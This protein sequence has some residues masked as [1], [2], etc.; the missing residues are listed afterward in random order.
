MI[1]AVKKIRD[2]GFAIEM[3]DFGTGYSALNILC[4]IPLDV[5]K[6]DMSFVRQ[7]D[8]SQENEKM[9]G[10]ILEMAKMLG[11]GVNAEGVE[12]AGQLEKL[13]SMGCDMVQGFYFSKP[14]PP[15]E[16]E[17]LIMK[18]LEYKDE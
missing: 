4:S 13:N 10:I 14:V 7:M 3:D 17:K 6:L 9:V 15:E 16:F 1:E 11:V 5:L 8:A 18:E 12:N 2:S